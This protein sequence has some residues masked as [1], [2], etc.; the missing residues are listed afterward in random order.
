MT[1]VIQDLIKRSS[2][3]MHSQRYNT[4]TVFLKR[5]LGDPRKTKD[6]RG[7][8]YGRASFSLRSLRCYQISARNRF[9]LPRKRNEGLVR[10]LK[11]KNDQVESRNRH[12]VYRAR[13]VESRR[14]R[15]RGR[16][17][18]RCTQ[19]TERSV[20]LYVY[21]YNMEPRKHVRRVQ[22]F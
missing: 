6:A 8:R 17:P 3:T 16:A 21:M 11:F 13:S 5:R 20:H 7:N 4:T 9:H 15:E 22:L 10:V 1:W 12:L 18:R 14:H 19:T 2:F